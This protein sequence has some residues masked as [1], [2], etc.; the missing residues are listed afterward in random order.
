MSKKV[1][2]SLITQQQTAYMQNRCNHRYWK[3][4]FDSL[5]HSFL[6]AVLKK[7]GF[8][9]ISDILEITYTLTLNLK[10]C[11]VIIDTEKTFKSWHHFFVM[12][13]LK[14]SGVGPGRI[15]K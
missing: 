3:K 4:T 2:P 15:Q 9:L 8:G 5:H 6:M 12:A 13:V 14:K 1:P 11:L 7:F 10:G